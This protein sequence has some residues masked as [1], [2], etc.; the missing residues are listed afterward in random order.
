MAAKKYDLDELKRVNLRDVWKHEAL[1]FTKWLAEEPNH[2]MLSDA[3]GVELELLETESSVGAF[4]V[5]IYAQESGTGRKVI[6]ENQLEDTNHDHLGKVITYAAGKGAEVVIWV[7]ARARDEHRQAIEW[8]NQHTDSEFGFFLVEV[9]LWQIGDSRPAPRFN[10]VEQPNEWAKT[11]KMSE[12]MSDTERVKLSYWTKYREIAEETPE[13]TAVFKPR[14]PSASHASDLNCGTGS[15]HF[16]LLIDTQAGKIGIELYVPDDKEIGR[17]AIENS[18]VFEERLGLKS[19]P[20]DARKASGV[21]L[22]KTGCRIKG[23]EAAWSG[24]IRE[25][26]RWGLE[27]RDVVAELGI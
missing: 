10:V 4:N 12:G 6:I 22:Y 27:M 8:L 15:Y 23:N 20:I 7:V 24:F 26:M 3:V 2:K 9:E 11:L 13:F 25:Q 19:E 18:A 14:K 16:A 5:D 17:K 21:R 1:D